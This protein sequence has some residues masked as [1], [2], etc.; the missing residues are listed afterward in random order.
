MRQLIVKLV[1]IMSLSGCS[2]QSGQHYSLVP[3]LVPTAKQWSDTLW[4]DDVEVRY[5]YIGNA[6]F[7]RLRN[8]GTEV[9][10]VSRT[11]SNGEIKVIYL[12]P[13]ERTDVEWHDL[14]TQLEDVAAICRPIE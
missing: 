13:F 12:P 6:Y 2:I 14:P 3:T 7:V 4:I 5:G 10:K 8:Q 9:C 11:Y 1:F